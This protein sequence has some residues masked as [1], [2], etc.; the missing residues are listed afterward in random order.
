MNIFTLML[1]AFLTAAA[2]VFV[3]FRLI[4]MYEE[5]KRLRRQW[6]DLYA[7]RKRFVELDVQAA[8]AQKVAL[9]ERDLTIYLNK[10]PQFDTPTETRV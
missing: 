7:V 2:A 8:E 6:N 10:R 9:L 5:L 1:S 4:D 3:L